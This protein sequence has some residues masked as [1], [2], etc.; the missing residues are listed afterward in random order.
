VIGSASRYCDLPVELPPEWAP[1][2]MAAPPALLDGLTA[3]FPQ[4]IVTVI[5]TSA[6]VGGSTACDVEAMEGFGVLRAAALAGVPAIEV[7]IVSNDIEEADRSRWQFEA[8]FDVI[9]RVT[10]QLVRAIT[11]ALAAS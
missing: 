10:P 4:A 11:T 8:A 3:A 7:R 1:H 9:A 6:R 2:T 5:G